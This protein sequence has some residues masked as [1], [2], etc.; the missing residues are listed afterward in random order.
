MICGVLGSGCDA[1][2][3]GHARRRLWRVSPGSRVTRVELGIIAL[4]Q[5]EGVGDAGAMTDAYIVSIMM[6]MLGRRDC[7]APQ[8]QR[9]RIILDQSLDLFERP[10]RTSKWRRCNKIAK[11][12]GSCTSGRVESVAG[13][14][15]EI[16]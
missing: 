10:T 2:G 16:F 4:Q 11:S 12:F 3:P 14:K 13:S 1:S 7:L 6:F 8:A 9:I 15:V 5:V